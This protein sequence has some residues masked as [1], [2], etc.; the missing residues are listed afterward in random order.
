MDGG[1]PKFYRLAANELRYVAYHYAAYEGAV[2]DWTEK[3]TQH[4]NRKFRF[5]PIDLSLS[6]AQLIK[7]LVRRWEGMQPVRDLYQNKPVPTEGD[8]CP[9]CLECTTASYDWEYNLSSWK[10]IEGKVTTECKHSFCK[11]CWAT[12]SERNK[13]Y[14]YS[15][16]GNRHSAPNF[17]VNCPLCRHKITIK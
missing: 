7:E 12:H 4:Y 5:R 14:D 9:I 15:A 10:K 3:N 13:R 6:K 16:T 2:H 17:C 1:C 11:K 8:E